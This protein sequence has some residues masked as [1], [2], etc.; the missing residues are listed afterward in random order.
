[1]R[2]VVI[3][4]FLAIFLS[5]LCP[6]AWAYEDTAEEVRLAQT[7]SGRSAEYVTDLSEGW[8]FGGAGENASAEDFPDD[9]WPAVN[10][11]HTWNKEDTVDGDGSYSRAAY[12]YRRGL[13]VPEPMD[14][15]HYYLEFLGAN[16]QTDLYVNGKHL[17]LCGSNS[18]THKGG[19]TAFRYDITDALQKG[20]NQLAVRVDNTY[21]EEIAP[22]SGDFNMYGGLYRRVFLITVNDLHFDL[23]DNGSSGLFLFTPNVRSKERPADLGTLNIRTTIINDGPAART[24]TVTAHIEGDNAPRD[25]VRTLNIEAGETVLFDKT[26]VISDPHLWNGA[27]YSG[28]SEQTDVGYLYRVTVSITAYGETLDAVTDR[29]GFRYFYVDKENGFYLNGKP[30]PLRGVNRHPSQRGLGSALLEANHEQ[31]MVLIEGMGANAVRL[32]HTPQADLFYDLCDEKGIIVWTEIP[33]VN[34]IGQEKGFLDTMKAQLTELIRQQGNRPSI[35]FWGLQNEL[36]ENNRSSFTDAKAVMSQLDDLAHQEDPSGRY[37]TQAVKS[38]LPLDDD[39]PDAPLSV[40]AENEWKSDLIAYNF[41]PG[42]YS[43]GD[44]ESAAEEIA[45]LDARPMGLSEYGWGANAAQHELYPVLGQNGLTPEGKRHPEEYQSQMHEAA[46]RYINTHPHLW[47]TFVWSLFDFDAEGL[48]EGSVPGQSDMGLVTNNRRTGKDA[49]YLYKANWDR[50][51]PLVHIVSSRYTP[52]S[53]VKTYVKVYSNCDSVALYQNGVLLGDMTPQGNGVFLWEDLTLRMGENKMRAVGGLNGRTMED[54]CLWLRPISH[55]TILASDQLAVDPAEGT[56]ILPHLMTVGEVK[57]ALAATNNA[58]YQIL[59]GGKEPAD[60]DLATTWMTAVV[61]SESRQKRQIYSFVPMNLL[62]GCEVWATSNQEGKLPEHAVDETKST[63]WTAVD[64][65]YPQTITAD[66]GEPHLLGNLLLDW[67]NKNGRYYTYTVETSMDGE[68]YLPA[69]DGRSNKTSGITQNSLSGLM[70]RYVRITVHSCS[71]PGGFASL[72][73]IRL[74]GWEISSDIYPLDHENRLI[75]VP[76][77]MGLTE[78]EF[79]DHLWSRG[80]RMSLSEQTSGL[81]QDGDTLAFTDVSGNTAVYTVATEKTASL[82]PFDAALHKPVYCSSEEG[83][84]PGGTVGYAP[85]ANDGLDKT[86]WVSRIDLNN[87]IAYPAWICVDLGAEY[88]LH[89]IDLR[90]EAGDQRIYKFQVLASSDTPPELAQSLP[91]NYRVLVDRRD[92]QDFQ[93]GTYSFSLE[94]E[95]AR[96]IAVLVVANSRF[97]QDMSAA[98]SIYDLKVFGTLYG[99]EQ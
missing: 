60:S 90:F 72:N 48:K 69:A 13:T 54:T 24:I 18:Y 6:A 17:R 43:E 33:L 8:L 2:K 9:S 50:R 83:L 97:P 15:K 10:L 22:L 16:Q 52:R 75:L 31:D 92:N 23:S 62:A 71:H 20:E 80:V 34:D 35:C 66:L 76:S 95:K 32:A 59:L 68:F 29:V 37:T 44:F 51:T 81:I 63:Q 96:Y 73:D 1:M 11:P 94:G 85:G 78:K 55:S 14:G 42:W 84:T 25:I 56:I 98:A 40:S 36:T 21:S 19:Y 38:D 99:A 49:F 70:A 93:N 65:Q 86:A 53:D 12:W 30:H 64:S 74:G 41:F 91:E 5:A 58:S 87:Q 28:E 57:E 77:T 79:S 7:A 3:I 82:Y 4:F 39:Q 89:K 47:G 88:S 46:L 61:V 26:V 67:P 45:G 27:D